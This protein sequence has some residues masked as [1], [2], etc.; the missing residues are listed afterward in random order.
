M[1]GKASHCCIQ[2]VTGTMFCTKT[3]R[4]CAWKVCHNSTLK[5][6]CQINNHSGTWP[7]L[8]AFL[9]GAPSLL[10][11]LMTVFRL[12]RISEEEVREFDNRETV[13]YLCGPPAMSDEVSSWINLAEVNYEKWW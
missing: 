1:A 2:G 6:F 3:S 10:D 8:A 7:I 11:C 12:G 13:S 5:Y 9:S 4:F